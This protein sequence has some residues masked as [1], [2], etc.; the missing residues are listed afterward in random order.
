M[1]ETIDLERDLVSEERKRMVTIVLDQLSETDRRI[2]KMLFF[3]E[4][5]KQEI[6]RVM[7]VNREYLR[8]LVHRARLRLRAAIEK[9][10]AAIP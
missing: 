4:T 3:D 10:E 6:C 7:G 2:L 9:V 8:V 1:D 5:D